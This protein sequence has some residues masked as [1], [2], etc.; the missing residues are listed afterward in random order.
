MPISMTQGRGVGLV[1][2]FYEP[3][4]QPARYVLRGVTLNTNNVAEGG[5]IVEV[6][7]TVSGALRGS[8]VSDA[9]GNYSL[10]VTGTEGLTFFLAVFDPANPDRSGISAYDLTGTPE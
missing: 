10:D 6:Y 1:Q 4:Q 9:N 2:R 8:T 3:T 5:L 7:E